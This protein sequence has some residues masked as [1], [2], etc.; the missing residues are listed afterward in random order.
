MLAAVNARSRRSRACG[1]AVGSIRTDPGSAAPPRVAASIHDELAA[2][3]R[4]RGPSRRLLCALA[5]RFVATRGWERLGFARLEDHARERLGLAARTLQDLAHVEAALSQHGLLAAALQEGRLGWTQTRLVARVATPASVASWLSFAERTTARA[6]AREVRRVDLGSLE[7][8][9]AGGAAPAGS[10]PLGGSEDTDEDGIA[11]TP[12][13]YLIVRCA[14]RVQAKWFRARGLAQRVAGE[15]VPPWQC[16]ESVAAEVLSGV[17]LT[18]EAETLLVEEETTAEDMGEKTGDRATSEVCAIGDRTG[19]GGAVAARA[20]EGIDGA[21]NGCATHAA[22]EECT[23]SAQ[24]LAAVPPLP[25]ELARLAVGLAAADAFALDARLR[26]ALAFEQRLEARMGTLLRRVAEGRRYR[27]LGFAS[28][29]RY[30]RD[31]LGLSARR[32]R[33]L[34][35]IERAA[36]RCPALAAAYRGARLSWVQ[37]N[38]LAALLLAVGPGVGAAWVAHAAAVSVRRLLHDVDAALSAAAGEAPPPLVP[39]ERQT[40][41]QP[42]AA[43]ADTPAADAGLPGDGPE[44]EREDTRV[45]VFVPREV[46]RLFRAAL[47]SMRRHLERE[48]GHLPTPGQ[49]FEAMLDHAAQAWAPERRRPRELAVFERDGWRCTVPG[50]SSL[51]NLHDHH[52][53]FRSQGGSDALSNRTTLCAWHHLRGVHRGIVRCTGKA[54]RGLR[55]ELGVRASGPPLAVFASGD[56][57]A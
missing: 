7:R 14:P 51:R 23:A 11:T 57:R 32:A 44:R 36:A 37:A 22:A 29:E 19:V 34:V 26:A 1:G 35:R 2:L 18:P 33:S 49:A 52:V 8:S 48:T 25:P 3:A 39:P 56:V 53:V 30:V 15:P 54:P 38:A 50:C 10:A 31:R 21:A 5:A 4:A 43:G 6:L 47:C 13:E 28:F 17:K 16:L 40:G 12:R 46:G 55:F 41:A 42:R 45:M 9:A 20:V 27:A 24:A